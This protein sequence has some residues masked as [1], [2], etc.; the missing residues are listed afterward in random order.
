MVQVIDVVQIEEVVLT[1][2]VHKEEALTEEVAAQNPPQTDAHRE[3]QTDPH[4]SLKDKS[5]NL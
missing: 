3:V 5:Q 4:I 1:E 2:A